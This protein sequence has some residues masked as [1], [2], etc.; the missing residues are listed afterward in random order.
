MRGPLPS[1]SAEKASRLASGDSAGN[2][3]PPGREVTRSGWGGGT[4]DGDAAEPG[5]AAPHHQATTATASSSTPASTAG[6]QRWREPGPFAG[7]AW[8][9]ASAA[10]SVSGSS[11]PTEATRA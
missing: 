4:G 11:G 2:I 7:S 10:G 6:S 1:G 3:S 8:A 5:P 9:G